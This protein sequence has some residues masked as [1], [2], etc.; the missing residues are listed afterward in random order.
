[1]QIRQYTDTHC[2]V[3]PQNAVLVD[4]EGTYVWIADGS[5]S[6]RR[7]V[8]AGGVNNQGTVITSGLHDGEQ[9]IVSGQNKVSDGSKITIQ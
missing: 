4:G 5:I 7:N 1:V 2:I 9:V 8:T 3:V 6:H